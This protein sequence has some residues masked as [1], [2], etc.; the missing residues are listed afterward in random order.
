M[1]GYYINIEEETVNNSNFRKVLY[2]GNYTQLVLMA[3]KPNEEIGMEVH[4]NDQFFRFEAGHGKVVVDGTEYEVADGHVVV[5]PAGAEHNVVNTSSEEDLKLYT[6]YSPPHHK[7][8][9][10][11]ET[12]ENA[13]ANEEE[14]DGNTSE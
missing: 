3:L 12:K 11:H 7:D 5:V 9:T 14:F 2:T 6:L 4:G 1:K 8:G 13:E 10:V